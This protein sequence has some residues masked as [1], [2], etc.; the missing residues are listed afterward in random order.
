MNK[1]D[2]TIKRN[3]GY[4]RYVAALRATFIGKNYKTFSNTSLP[5]FSRHFGSEPER[6]EVSWWHWFGLFAHSRFNLFP[7]STIGALRIFFRFVPSVILACNFYIFFLFIV[8]DL[9]LNI[10]YLIFYSILFF[11]NSYSFFRTVMIFEISTYI[12]IVRT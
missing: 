2:Y 3:T 8:V 4:S 1:F 9:K 12:I 7:Q 11:S 5:E 10:R 6:T